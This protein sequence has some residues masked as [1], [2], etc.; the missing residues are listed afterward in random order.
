MS[1]E[2]VLKDYETFQRCIDTISEKENGG[3]IE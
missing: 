1:A 2:F 3:H